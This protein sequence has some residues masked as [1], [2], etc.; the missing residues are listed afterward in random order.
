MEQFVM[1]YVANAIWQIPLLAT[2]AWVFIRLGRFGPR[3]Q[4]FIWLAVV[5]LS[6][7]LPLRGASGDRSPAIFATHVSRRAAAPGISGREEHA[8]TASVHHSS[9][10]SPTWLE[11]LSALRGS[12]LRLSETATG[13]LTGTYFAILLIGLYRIARAWRGARR[14]VKDSQATVLQPHWTGLFED[15]GR[16][17]GTRLPQLRKSCD[18][19][20]PVI[21][22]AVNPVLLLPQDFDEHSHDEARAAFYHELAHVRRR[23]YLGNIL[24]QLAVLPVAWHPVI[25]A[26]QRRIR[27]TRE[28]ACDAI[29]ARE[30]QSEIGYA[31]CL[32]T[33]AGRTL[34]RRDLAD[35]QAMGLFGDNVLEERIMRLMQEKSTMT[36][37]AKMVRIASGATVMVFATVMAASFHVTPTLAQ[38]K[39]VVSPVPAQ[40]AAAP[41]PAATPVP[42]AAPTPATDPAPVIPPV[43][44]D[45]Q[46]TRRTARKQKISQYRD[47][48]AD[49]NQIATRSDQRQLG[50]EIDGDHALTVEQTASLQKEMDSMNAQI[51][52]AAKHLN[53]PEFQRQMA[54]LAK[55]QTELKNI[56]LAKIQ[57]QIDAATAKIDSPEFK[58]QMEKLQKQMESGEMQRSMAEASKRLKEAEAQQQQDLKLLDMSKIQQQ[59]DAATAKINSPEFKQQMEKLQ[60]QM[61]SGEMQRSMAEAMKQLK[62][63]ETQMGNA[64]TK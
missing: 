19:G 20:S 23:D 35:A 53:S 61:E 38:S 31:K 43:A 56:N 32:L 46:K 24:C 47:E 4:H 64:Q 51:A 16:R 13:W 21:V 49:R 6:V 3:T 8:S 54:D 26:V 9:A 28:M 45:V 15:C 10:A 55:Q 34:G 37:P 36:M 60:K 29:A 48:S 12:R 58:Q 57:Q 40:S 25:Y 7:G 17:L 14:L 30:M 1:G 27:R 50:I 2:A 44:Q 52:A 63:A 59:I 5:A 33:M 22:G 11:K 39:P 42:E 41:H 62:A 18:V